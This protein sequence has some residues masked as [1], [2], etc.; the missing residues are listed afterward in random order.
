MC[1][2]SMCPVGVVVSCLILVLGTQAESSTKAASACFQSHLF[3]LIHLSFENLKQC[4]SLS[5]KPS[6]S[7]RQPG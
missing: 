3:S 6:N 5:W 2:P 4:L 7:L 1:A